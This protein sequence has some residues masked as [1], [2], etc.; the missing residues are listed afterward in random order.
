MVACHAPGRATSPSKEIADARAAAMSLC[1]HTTLPA[2]KTVV[3][4]A[5]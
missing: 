4:G 3:A 5:A 1:T 2:G